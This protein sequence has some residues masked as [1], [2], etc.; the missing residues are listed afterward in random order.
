MTL[1]FG[2]SDGVWEL[3]ESRYRRLA[4]ADKEV[5]HVANREGTTLAAVPHWQPVAAWRVPA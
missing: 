2:T 4:P 3:K 1:V 5:S